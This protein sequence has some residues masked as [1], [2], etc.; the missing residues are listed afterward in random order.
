MKF[1]RFLPSTAT[2]AV[3]G[4]LLA[5]PAALAADHAHGADNGTDTRQAIALDAREKHFLLSEMRQF[6]AVVQ[7]I[8]AA[9]HAGDMKEVAQAATSAG[10][11]A[12]QADFADPNSLV[13]G[14]RKKAPKE[15]FPLGK[16]T[17]EAF[18]E[19]A[20]VASA[21][22]DKDTVN[23]MLADNLQRCVACHAAYRVDDGHR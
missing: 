14:I 4:A 19:I 18:D 11:K 13:H 9:S 7:R 2:V 3:L 8:L 20:S 22:G 1:A 6:L 21:I 5:P 12:H 16:A 10:L 15:F 17:H 23:K